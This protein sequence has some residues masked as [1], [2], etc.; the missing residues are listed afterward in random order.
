A[1]EVK[2]RDRALRFADRAAKTGQK[3]SGLFRQ[4]D[5][6]SERFYM[7]QPILVGHHSERGARA[8][9]N[10]MHNKMDAALKEEK[11]AEYYSQRAESAEKNKSI[12]SADEDAIVKLKAKLES[13]SKVQERMKQANKVV[14]ASKLSDA[15]KITKLQEQGFSE[16]KAKNLLEKDFAGRVGFPAYALQNN[17]AEMSRLKK[18]IEEL[19]VKQ[20]QQTQKIEFDGG[21]IVDNVAEN[22]L[23]IFFDSKPD[24][25]T[26]EK[27]KSNGFRWAPSA[28]AW[29]MHRSTWANRKAESITG[30]KIPAAQAANPMSTEDQYYNDLAEKTEQQDKDTA[31]KELVPELTLYKGDGVTFQYPDGREFTATVE[32]AT[33]RTIDGTPDQIYIRVD[34]NNALR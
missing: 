9:Q 1:A 13:L 27:L 17:N 25:A 24:E 5:K 18:R 34:V 3:A 29:Q 2:R 30:V 31:E 4:A 14:K 21:E 20:S 32:D 11:K 10:R 26:R 28:G 19:S 22:R 7:G 8:A 15:E 33:P 23:Q 12:S 16:A 6:I